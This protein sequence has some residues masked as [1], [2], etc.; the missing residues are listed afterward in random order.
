M[1]YTLLSQA[2]AGLSVPAT[3]VFIARNL[4]PDEQGYYFTFGSVVAL[5]VL[6]ELGFTQCIVQFVAHEY[7][8]LTLD[9]TGSVVGPKPNRD[10]LASIMQLAVRWYLVAATLILIALFLAGDWVFPEGEAG[11]MWKRPWYALCVATA[12]AIVVEPFWAVL[13][14]LN[15]I[16]WVA[17]SR[18]IVNIA[19]ILA[20]CGSLEVGAGLMAL[21]LAT[22][23]SAIGGGVLIGTRWRRLLVSLIAA[24]VARHD[25]VSWRSEIW[26]YQWRIALSW[27]SGYFIIPIV[28][29]T[30]FRQMGAVPAGQFGMTWTI[31]QAS[32]TFGSTWMRTRLPSL[33]VLAGRGDWKELES[34]WRVSA[35]RSMSFTAIA[36]LAVVLVVIFFGATGSPISTR[37]ASP[38][39]VALLAGGVVLSQLVATHATYLRVQKSEPFTVVSVLAAATTVALTLTLTPRIGLY[40]PAVAFATASLFCV[41]VGLLIL[42]AHARTD[43]MRVGLPPF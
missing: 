33:G 31:V 6:V 26:P 1:L 5:Q 41:P 28:A 18:L 15:Q 35:R 17:K 20:I 21:A 36:A 13:E 42:R 27:V 22:T 32:A 40:G 37:L 9:G 16:R 39:V 3:L 29:P 12:V 43:P 10:R 34:Q 19:K 14:G 23:V 38:G 2:I 8:H 25:K 7:G 11:A 4:S 30:V 24:R